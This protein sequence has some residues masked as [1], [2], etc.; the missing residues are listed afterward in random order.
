M[1]AP[2]IQADCSTSGLRLVRGMPGLQTAA[3]P[4]PTAITIG[5]FDGL[6]RGHR[7]LLTQLVMTA[8]SRG[9]VPTVLSFEPHPRRWFAEQ[10]GLADAVPAALTGLRERLRLLREAGIEL[11]ILAR[12]NQRLAQ[13]EARSFVEDGL[14]QG[15][16]AR[17]LLIGADFRFGA[18]RQGDVALLQSYV[19]RLGLESVRAIDDVCLESERISSSAVRTALAAGDLQHATRLLGRAPGH[20][21]RVIHGAKLGRSLGFP[22]M[23]LRLPAG[24]PALSGILVVRILGL[25]GQI[26]YGV[27][28]LGR[29][30]TVESNGRPLLEVFVFDW[31]GN[32]Y[33]KLVRVE[34]LHKLR[35]ELQFSS[36]DSLVQAMQQDLA[37][38]RAWLAATPALSLPTSPSVA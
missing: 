5:N 31:Q 3:L 17:E 16:S 10:R 35:D 25:D 1:P 8:R 29:R 9:L 28:S 18:R 2:P 4:R 21:A 24:P 26:R 19:G 33:G 7:E 6:H 12:F 30:P 37:Q 34:Y 38:A 22:T 14:L 23:N 11:L 20:E 32:A 13:C 15:C 27:A 36:L